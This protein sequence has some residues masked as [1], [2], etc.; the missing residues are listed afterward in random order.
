MQHAMPP[1]GNLSQR[2]EASDSDADE[3]VAAAPAAEPVPK[4]ARGCAGSAAARRVHA[5]NARSHPRAQCAPRAAATQGARR[6]AAGGCTRDDARKG[7]AGQGPEAQAADRCRAAGAVQVEDAAEEVRRAGGEQQ[8]RTRARDARRL[9]WL[10]AAR[11]SAAAA[12]GAG[13]C[14]HARRTGIARVA[15]AAPR[16]TAWTRC[17]YP[18]RRALRRMRA[19]PDKRTPR[20]HRA[21]ARGAVCTA[22]RRF[23]A[24]HSVSHACRA[25]ACGRAR[26]PSGRGSTRARAALRP[27]RRAHCALFMS[28]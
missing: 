2:D 16:R 1:H 20:R 17:A 8:Q 27:A 12:R 9:L 15:G 6:K 10:Q 5:L 23:T 4:S 13:G 3:R 21:R 14:R 18:P 7:G 19:R 22:P 26:A 24:S 11:C 28:A 25:H